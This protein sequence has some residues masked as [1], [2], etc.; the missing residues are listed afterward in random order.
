PAHR[1]R[2]L[3]SKFKPSLHSDTL[4]A[5]CLLL[6]RFQIAVVYIYGGIAKLTPDWF[7]GEPMRIW[8]NHRSDYPLIGPLLETEAAVAFFTYG[9]LLFDLLIVPALLWKP[10]RKWAFAACLFFHTT[11]AWFFNIGIFPAAMVAASTLFFAPDWPRKALLLFSPRNDSPPQP[12]PNKLLNPALLTFLLL[13]ATAQLLI[14]FRHLLY[15]G[16][17][18]WTEEGHRFSWHMKLRT[19]SASVQF[20]AHDPSTNQTWQINHNGLL[21][22][23]QSDRVGR[24]PEMI[25]QFA[26]YLAENFRR[27]GHPNIQIFADSHA[28]LNGRE[29]QLLIDPTIDLAQIKRSLAP[30]PWIK[31]LTHPLP[32]KKD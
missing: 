30:H 24:F 19:K 9:G 11:N 4:P 1:A 5:W 22:N 15:P 13:F 8:L 31:P 32:T 26:H 7:R 21:S 14:P 23:A 3:D 20:T 28:S 2:S 18:H 27:E 25:L 16:N 10:S 12:Q 29:P 17:V 6:L